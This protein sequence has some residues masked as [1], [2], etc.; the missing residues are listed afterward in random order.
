MQAQKKLMVYLGSESEGRLVT[1]AG[2][3]MAGVSLSVVSGLGVAVGAIA[4]ALAGTDTRIGCGGNEVCHIRM[5]LSLLL[6][7]TLLPSGLNATE[8]T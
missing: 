7:A 3:A 2:V 4:L 8:V 1:G 5:V 6:E